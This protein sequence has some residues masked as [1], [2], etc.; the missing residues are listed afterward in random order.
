MYLCFKLSYYKR[1]KKLNHLK[2]YEV[3]TY[4][5]FGLIYSWKKKLYKQEV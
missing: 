4:Y 5:K 1:L 3:K 2:V